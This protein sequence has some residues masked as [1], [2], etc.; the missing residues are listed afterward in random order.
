MDR[1][2]FK[3]RPKKATPA[4]PDDELATMSEACQ[5]LRFTEKTVRTKAKRGELPGKM[6]LGEW[7]FSWS[8]LREIAGV[9]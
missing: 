6:V 9:G 2:Q 1:K 4:T 3:T 7:R 5:F 8:K